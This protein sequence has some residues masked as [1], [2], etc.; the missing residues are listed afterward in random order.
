[1][2]PR[3]PCHP[4]LLVFHVL[5]ALTVMVIHSFAWWQRDDDIKKT[6]RF[7]VCIRA[8]ESVS[9]V[10]AFAEKLMAMVPGAGRDQVIEAFIA[11]DKNAEMAANLLFE[12][13]L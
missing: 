4:R 6:P 10:H 7:L 5:R 11:C 12:N 1:M 8:H 13:A 2:L 3:C 9:L